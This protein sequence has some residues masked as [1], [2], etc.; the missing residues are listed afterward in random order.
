MLE[1]SYEG[2]RAYRQSKLAQI[3]FTFE[4]PERLGTEG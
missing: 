1:R 4:M 3:M 2:F